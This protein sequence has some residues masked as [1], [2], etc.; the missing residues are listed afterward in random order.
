LYYKCIFQ[1]NMVDS[2][3]KLEDI[4]RTAKDLFWKYGFK[5][6][7]I[8]EICQKANVSK[9]T[10]YKHFPNKIELAKAVFN[11]VVEEGEQKLKQ[12]LKEDSPA[13]VKMQKIFQ[14]KVDGSNDISEEFL[15]DF[16]MGTEPELKTYVEE[17]I[18]KTWDVLTDDIKEAQKNG[19]FRKSFKPELMIKVQNKLLEML[20]DESVINMY[21]SQQELILEFSNLML[22]GISPHD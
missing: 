15:Q 21:N 2:N 4:R 3:K 1:Y 7:S 14:I 12:I 8:E 17:R 13:T 19:V 11:N 22:Y 5:R 18:R 20:K 6:V 16:Y 9:M 10:Y